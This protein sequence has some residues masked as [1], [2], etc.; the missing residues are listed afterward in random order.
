M[1]PSRVSRDVARFDILAVWASRRRWLTS[2][3]SEPCRAN[4][5]VVLQHT[6]SD[7]KLLQHEHLPVAQYNTL[8][9]N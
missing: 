5:G 2:I 4:A 8:D 3:L 1:P 6:D 7:E 9:S